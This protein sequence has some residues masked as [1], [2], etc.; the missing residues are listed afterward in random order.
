MDVGSKALLASEA[1]ASLRAPAPD[2]PAFPPLFASGVPASTLVPASDVP[3]QPLIA[4][5][6]PKSAA[7]SQ[8]IPRR[9]RMSLEHR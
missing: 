2:A 9:V 4:P 5:M 8:S 7:A 6:E 3:P 1:R